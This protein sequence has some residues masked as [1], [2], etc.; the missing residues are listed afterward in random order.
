MACKVS[1]ETVLRSCWKEGVSCSTGASSRITALTAGD[2][3]LRVMRMAA[4]NDSTRNW[5]I[6]GI[7]GDGWKRSN[8]RGS[9]EQLEEESN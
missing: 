3:K 5:G 6:E 1:S 8:S 2:A 4:R 7:F 9:I